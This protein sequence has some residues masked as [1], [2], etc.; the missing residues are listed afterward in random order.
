MNLLPS[1]SSIVKDYLESKLKDP[2][3]A[4]KAKPWNDKALLAKK[5]SEDMDAYI[6]QLKIELKAEAGAN[7]VEKDGKQVEE[8]KKD[9]LE[10]ATRLFGNEKGGKNKGPEFEKKLI[11][12]RNAMLAID[13]EIKK[14]FEK[15]T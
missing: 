14:E 12:F 7:M 13:P 10:A 9:D 2:T 15:T 3:T 1:I 8:Y 6:N 11:A 4:E 5:L